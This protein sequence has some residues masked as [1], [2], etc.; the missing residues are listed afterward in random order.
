MAFFLSLAV[1]EKLPESQNQNDDEKLEEEINIPEDILPQIPVK[2]SMRS[3]SRSSVKTMILRRF[4]LR[5]L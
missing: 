3:M 4:M 2:K 1:E 5:S